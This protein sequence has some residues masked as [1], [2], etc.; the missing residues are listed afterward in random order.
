MAKWG[1]TGAVGAAH[2][3]RARRARARAQNAAACSEVRPSTDF[4]SRVTSSRGA[5]PPVSASHTEQYNVQSDPPLQRSLRPAEPPAS[6]ADEQ[7][8][9][10]QMEPLHYT[11]SLRAKLES[12]VDV[13]TNGQKAE[14]EN[15]EENYGDATKGDDDGSD[16]EKNKDP[17][18]HL[19]LDALHVYIPPSPPHHA[20]R[21]APLR[22]KTLDLLAPSGATLLPFAHPH[23][24]A[25]F[26]L[27]AAMPPRVRPAL[28]AGSAAGL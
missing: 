13:S 26:V 7:G 24:N 18:D 6:S 15:D 5:T 23:P 1:A 11:A 4:I 9:A 22:S 3:V 21:N 12:G 8:D 14:E 17:D 10:F 19:T 16:D 28:H 25:I 2:S 20:D 27:R